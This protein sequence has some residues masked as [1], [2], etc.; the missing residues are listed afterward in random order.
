MI[1]RPPRSTRT[2]TLFPY[3]TLFRSRTGSAQIDQRSGPGHDLSRQAQICRDGPAVIAMTSAAPATAP[4]A[5]IELLT[6]PLPGKPMLPHVELY[7]H[8]GAR[9]DWFNF[10]KPVASRI[11]DRHVRRESTHPEQGVAVVP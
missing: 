5:R 10:G 1:R 3:T 6:A 8:A 2:D 7:W 11:G 4:S 9:E